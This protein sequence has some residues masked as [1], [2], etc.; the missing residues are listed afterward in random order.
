MTSG[1]RIP[2]P[3]SERPRPEHPRTAGVDPDEEVTLTVYLRPGAR[4]PTAEEGRLSRREWSAAA[5][6]A[7]DDLDAFRRFCA[8]FGLSVGRV[9][10]ARRAVRV[11]GTVAAVS[12][13]FGTELSVYTAPDGSSYRARTGSLSLPD[14][15]APVVEGVFGLDQRP[16]A[17]P[18]F[19][20]TSAAAVSY[21]PVQVADAYGAPAG[22]TGSGQTIALIELGG[23]YRT[24]D[25][26]AYFSSLGLSSPSVTAVGVDGGTNAPSTASSADGEVML[27]IEVAGAVAPGADIVAY[28]APNTDQGFLDAV[29]T[30]VHD[31]THHPS[32]VSISWG[33]AESTWTTQAMNQ[34]ESAFAAAATLG[35]TVT[36]AAG[37]GGST[38]GQSDGSQHVDFPA[39]A[40]HALACGGTSLRL[41][42]G[43]ITSEVV[44]ND[45]AQGGGATGGGISTVFPVPSYQSAAHVPPS[46]NPGGATGRGVPDVAGDADPDTGYTVRVDGSTVVIGGTSA[47]AP[48][49]AGL[50]ARVNQ[51]LGRD[52]GW[53]NPTIYPLAETP[54]SSGAVVNDITSG[55]NGAYSAAPG[56][57][58]CTGL[59]SPRA[60]ALLAALAAAPAPSSPAPPST[61][62]TPS[63]PSS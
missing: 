25:I 39:S 46:A 59:G 21:T 7:A 36:V 34:L 33:G 56:W 40:P 19:R 57:D 13:A 17:R 4:L 43:A 22:T 30:A 28:F 63:T 52:V 26:D 60:G 23:G 10:R 8:D 9:D 3:G 55:N 14:D 50:L 2:L 32:F 20:S 45:S 58:A 37:D 16:Q 53:L 27:D 54:P 48:M 1:N 35:V 51:S 24:A 12:Y 15:V 29:T 62:S 42:D 49:W 11:S 61:P 44:W 5:A 47:V 38:D 18:H 41:T 6:P 31:T